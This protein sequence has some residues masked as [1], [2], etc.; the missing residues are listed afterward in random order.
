M[1]QALWAVYSLSSLLLLLW[2]CNSNWILI[3]FGSLGD[4]N[5]VVFQNSY[6]KSL[7]SDVFLFVVR[8]H[9]SL[10]E[11][12][13]LGLGLKESIFFFFNRHQGFFL[14]FT[15][16][17]PSKKVAWANWAY[18]PHQNPTLLSW[19]GCSSLSMVFFVAVWANILKIPCHPPLGVHGKQKCV[20]NMIQK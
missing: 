14:F 11:D 4:V 10:S 8:K 15:V 19:S 9:L 18:C 5:W 3:Q 17:K 16:W 6:L 12:P 7:S 13:L 20:I 2:K 1:L